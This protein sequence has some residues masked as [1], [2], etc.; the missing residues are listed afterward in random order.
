MSTSRLLDVAVRAGGE[1]LA[2]G[3]TSA[4]IEELI[5]WPKRLSISHEFPL[6]KPVRT[7]AEALASAVIAMIARAE[8]VCRAAQRLVRCIPVHRGLI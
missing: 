5:E 1:R 4:G 6:K 7:G 8:I 3:R 2:V